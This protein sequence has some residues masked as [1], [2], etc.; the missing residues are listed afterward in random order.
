MSNNKRRNKNTVEAT[1]ETAKSPVTETEATAEP[2]NTADNKDEGE[3]E[4]IE[5]EVSETSADGTVTIMKIRK[6]REKKSFSMRIVDIT[7][8]LKTLAE[9]NLASDK[10]AVV[11]RV[12]EIL[13]DTVTSLESLIEN[14]SADIEILAATGKDAPIAEIGSI[15]EQGGQRFE[16]YAI[17]SGQKKGQ[18]ADLRHVEMKAFTLTGMALTTLKVVGHV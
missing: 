10:P 12:R 9:K 13:T 11:S 17:R 14:Y 2:V 15:V 4:E 5:T 18:V 7:G 8:L 1:V 16:V 3:T 6:T